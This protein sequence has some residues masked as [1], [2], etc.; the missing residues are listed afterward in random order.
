MVGGVTKGLTTRRASATS[1]GQWERPR[2]AINWFAK[3][4]LKKA[5][6]SARRR[7]S[8]LW[9]ATG[10]QGGAT[11]GFW[12]YTAKITSLEGLYLCYIITPRARPTNRGGERSA[13]GV[14]GLERVVGRRGGIKK[15]ESA[16]VEEKF[17]GGWLDRPTDRPTT[18]LMNRNNS[19]AIVLFG[20]F[21][22]T[23]AAPP[24]LSFLPGFCAI[25]RSPP[26]FFFH[27]YRSRQ[28]TSL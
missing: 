19:P 11:P 1:R 7:G 10:V 14:N 5:L 12:A 23:V 8:P 27:E 15:K 25:L 17:F 13:R 9:P 24:T 26:I 28:W 21:Q 22:L 2:Y 20:S 6:L 18:R 16:L 3:A 4:F